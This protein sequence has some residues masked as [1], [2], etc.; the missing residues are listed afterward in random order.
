VRNIE[1]IQIPVGMLFLILM[2]WVLMNSVLLLT[3]LA[4]VVF[5]LK[6]RVGIRISFS[7]CYNE[8]V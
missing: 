8:E 1:D 2:L 5:N 7:S 6:I 3:I 4:E